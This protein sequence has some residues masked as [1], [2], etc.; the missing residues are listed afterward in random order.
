MRIA[1]IATPEALYG[2]SASAQT[3]E[4]IDE[5]AISPVDS[6]EVTYVN[7]ARSIDMESYSHM[8]CFDDPDG[9]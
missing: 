9:I 6:E 3:F 5:T 4:K 7:I 2:A 1:R 8:P